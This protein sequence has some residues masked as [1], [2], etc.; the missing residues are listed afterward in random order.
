LVEW[1]FLFGD[2]FERHNF[3]PQISQ[4]GY[5]LMVLKAEDKV[6]IV[7]RRLFEKDSTRFFVGTV[8]DCEAGLA[9]VTGFTFSKDMMT[10]HVHKKDDPRTKIVAI[11]SGTVLVYVLTGDPQID[12]LQFVQSG[13][14]F[15]LIDG[16]EFQM[17]LTEH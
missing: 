12:K 3:R 5:P 7:H 2:E 14:K 1:A 6:L 15:K 17:D 16:N 4:Q 13:T 9:K 11:G 8:E 10:A